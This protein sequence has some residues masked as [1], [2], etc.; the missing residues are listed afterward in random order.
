[1][2]LTLVSLWAGRRVGVGGDGATGGAR[3]GLGAVSY[4][5]SAASAPSCWSLCVGAD[6]WGWWGS[7]EEKENVWMSWR[8]ESF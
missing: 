7:G 2:P 3:G 6:W 5:R 1:M 4:D 8:L